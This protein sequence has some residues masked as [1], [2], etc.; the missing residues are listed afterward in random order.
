MEY[1]PGTIESKWKKKWQDAN[2]YHVEIDKNKPKYYILDMFPYPSGAGLH[3]G[4]PLGY[5]ATDIFSR[6]KRHQGYNVLHPMGFDAFGLPAE[7]YAIQT[8]VKPQDSTRQNIKRY[9]EQ[10]DNLSF[11]YDW[12]R[13]VMT[14]DSNYY[15]WTQWIF[16]RLFDHYFDTVENKAKPISHL[17]T[18]FE[19]EGSLPATA[20]TDYNKNFSADQWKSFSAK[21]K[22]DILM[23]Y[24]LAYK[25]QAFVNW[26]EELGTVLANDEV[27]DGLSERGGYPVVKKPME[28]WFLR[29]TAFAERLLSDM[30]NLEWSDAL[31]TMQENWIG[32]SEGAQ[33]FFN[34]LNTDEVIEIFTTRPDTIFGA[35]FMVLAPEHEL[36]SKLTTDDQVLAVQNYVNYVKTRSERER[37]SETKQVTG[38]FTGSYAKHPF[39]NEPI[40]IW[41]SEYV[42]KDYGSGAIMAVPA[43]D[44]RDKVFA[45]KFS[46]PI[47]EIIDRKDFPKAEI[48]DKVG[49]MVNSDF[50]NGLEVKE[51][52]KVAINKI[53]ERGIGKARINYRLRD[54]NF[55]RQ[56][57][58]GEPFPIKYDK[59]GV[60]YTLS[61]DE[62]P[63]VLPELD[64]FKPGEKGQSPLAR[65][66]DWVNLPDGF[67]R[68]TDTMPGFAGSSWYFLR[69]M[70]NQN[71][72]HFA[73]KEAIDYWQN[74]DLYV[75]GTEHAVGHL[76]YSRFWHKFLFDIGKVP[77]NEPFKKL[78]N[79]G[80]IQGRSNFVFR[81]KENFFE[82]YIKLKVLDVY[83]QDQGIKQLYE[84]DFEEDHYADWGFE[85]SDLEIE[86]VSWKLKEKI[87]R[88]KE[89]VWAKGKRL[90][91]LSNEE[92]AN[93]I[94]QPEIIAQKIQSALDSKDKFI[95][96]PDQPDV[97]QLF[98]SY[99][100]TPKYSADCFNPIHVDVNMVTNDYLNLEVAKT[101]KQFENACFKLDEN[102]QFSCSWEVEKMSKSKYNVVNPDDMV[103][104]YGADCF[105]MYE[106]FL[107]PID[108]AKPWDTKGIDGVAKFLR[109]LWSLFFDENGQIQLSN[110][111]PS[112]EE[113][114]ILHQCIKRV[115]DDIERFSFNTCISAFMVFVNEIKRI[116]SKNQSILKEFLILIS[117]FAPH[118]A[119]ELWSSTGGEFSVIN[120][121]YPLCNEKYLI[122][123]LID[124]PVC[125][126][127]KKRAL[128]SLPNDIDQKS[129]IEK[130]LDLPEIQKWLEGTPA[131]KVIVVPGKMINVVV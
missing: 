129:A 33:V 53:V 40:E 55:S 43:G 37:I 69:Y 100:L 18:I 81:A 65:V 21:E 97:N 110:E 32:K 45:E 38:A 58:W 63:L 52:I 107:G 17:I 98:V 127:G 28:Q 96:N 11:S 9:R 119:E 2:I 5:I 101:K 89:A 108:Q 93:C 47:V 88:I 59:D 120:Q 10:L 85:K 123:D 103:A 80:M 79:Q 1:T 75:G 67:R 118:I 95:F 57:Y 64:D 114:K 105:R 12:S 94:N 90:L 23:N 74:V 46:L 14:S 82:E 117:P 16:I 20:F 35:T 122:E 73:S 39:T 27:K 78:I 70:D 48:E 113:L 102:K 7:Q 54:A 111:E 106:M 8:G 49:L 104:A 51:A 128:L 25:G 41:I 130:A 29:I 68:E 13:E 4:H 86:V 72:Q 30:Q 44:L 50:L 116:Q 19:T 22:N 56:R 66:T 112:K 77:T 125:I 76:M 87:D 121:R 126:N 84:G 31:K 131:K 99:N 3:V 62:L 61:D 92:I 91:V 109:R 71:D 42:L 6:F 36:V 24:R 83:F 115:T 124:Y 15:K 60:C 26:C 34:V